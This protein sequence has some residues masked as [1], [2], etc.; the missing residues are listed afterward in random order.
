MRFDRLVTRPVS[1]DATMFTSCA[2]RM[3]RDG[4]F[5]IA[6]TSSA[7]ERL[8]VHDA[9]LE[10]QQLRRA[11]EVGD[12]LGRRRRVAAHERQRRRADEQRLQAV[13]A[14]LV[15]GALGQRVLDDPQRRV[16]VAQLAAQLGGLHDA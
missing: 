4:S 7:A 5:A 11:G 1:G 10:R 6:E 2:L 14:G 16:G 8:A 13:R 9:A 15:G 12:R 3:S